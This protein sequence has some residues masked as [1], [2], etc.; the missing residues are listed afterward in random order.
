[1][2]DVSAIQPTG[3]LGHS[4]VLATESPLRDLESI[5]RS[6]TPLIAVESNEEPQIVRLVREIGER[7][8]LRGFR[9]TVTEGLQAFDPNDQPPGAILKSHE[10]LSHIRTSANNSFFVLLDF[11]PYLQDAVHVR[12]LKDIA[13]SYTKHYSTVV[14]VGYTVPV[15]EE[16][17][18]FTAQFRLPLP[19]LDELRGI[20]LDV[21]GE[22]GAE[23]GRRDV[24]TTNKALEL[25]VRNLGG[26]TATD[27]RRLAAKAINDDGVIDESDIPRVMQAKYELLGRDS[28]LTFEYET[29]RFSEIGGMQRL[30]KWIEM[31]KSFFIGGR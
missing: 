22:W 16:L 25:L 28:P 14:I 27:A 3:K 7:L 1:M 17:R 15:P 8:Q 13:L 2:A 31:R 9:W 12:H 19:M 29:A 21:A 10:V 4:T 6:R 5:I 11:H 18:P 24:Q 23:H 26:L 30:R 20:V